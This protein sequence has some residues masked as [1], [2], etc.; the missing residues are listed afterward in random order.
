MA[1]YQGRQAARLKQ[2]GA[3]PRISSAEEF[4]QFV[5]ADVGKWAKLIRASGAKLQ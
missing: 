3:E 4:S 2:D 1:Y 5:E